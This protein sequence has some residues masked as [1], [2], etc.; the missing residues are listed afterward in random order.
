MASDDGDET[1]GTI[2]ININININ[3]YIYIK[4]KKFFISTTAVVLV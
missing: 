1:M 2:Y 3:I 4:K